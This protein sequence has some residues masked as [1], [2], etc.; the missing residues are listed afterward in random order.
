MIEIIN[1]IKTC[2]ACP[3]QWEG[4]TSDGRMIYIR[5]RWSFLSVR[6]SE[7]ET[8]DIMKAVD[9]EEIFGYQNEKSGFDG[10]LKYKELKEIIEKFSSK[11]ILPETDGADEENGI[12]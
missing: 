2:P 6:I 3:A 7:K 11:I 8:T 12:F 10:F 1:L 4:T 5:Y 9:G